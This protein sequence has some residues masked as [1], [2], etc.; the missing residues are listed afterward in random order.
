MD[1]PN[2]NISNLS[3]LEWQ[4]II[5]GIKDQQC[6]VCTGAGVFSLSG[7]STS[8]VEQLEAYLRTHQDALKIRVQ[9][10]GWFHLQSGGSDGPAYQAVRNFYKKIEPDSKRVLEKLAQLKLHLLLSITPDRHLQKAFEEQHLPHRFDAYVRN[11]PDRNTDAPT[12]DMPLVYN[13]IGD[14]NIRNSLVLTF[15]DFYDYL[16][17]VFKGNSMSNMLK[18][19]ILD[20]QYFLFIGIPFDQWFV[21]LFMRILRQ[22]KER[23]NRYATGKI[24]R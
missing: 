5:Q 8:Q 10:N 15:D 7:D 11:Q 20:A 3:E 22:H 12:A 1:Q 16:E 13:M 21:H 17:S 18:N 14:I 4:A 23:K 24:A 6:V 19:N 9:E 2:P